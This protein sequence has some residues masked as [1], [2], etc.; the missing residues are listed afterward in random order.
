VIASLVQVIMHPY[1]SLFQVLTEAEQIQELA[2]LCD[3][4][5]PEFL[6]VTTRAL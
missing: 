6:A 4:S 2:W 1:H 3:S 5:Y